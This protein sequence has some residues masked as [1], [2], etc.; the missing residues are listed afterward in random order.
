MTQTEKQAI[1]LCELETRLPDFHDRQSS[2]CFFLYH[3]PP[4]KC[5]VPT[6]CYVITAIIRTNSSVSILLVFKMY[7]PACH[8]LRIYFEGH[9]T[10]PVFISFT[11]HFRRRRYSLI[12]CDG[13]SVSWSSANHSSASWEICRHAGMHCHLSVSCHIISCPAGLKCRGETKE[14][15]TAFWR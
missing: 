8:L 3:L 13:Y 15:S 7:F 1:L 6:H 2:W 11:V 5:L 12:H 4:K 14:I 9:S 10:S